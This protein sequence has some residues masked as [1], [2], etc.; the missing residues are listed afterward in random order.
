MSFLQGQDGQQSGQ[1]KWTQGLGFVSVSGSFSGLS[2]P[3]AL[4]RTWVL[5][6]QP[7]PLIKADVS[8]YEHRCHLEYEG[9]SRRITG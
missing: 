7:D 6:P 9:V 8:L 3:V 2:L 1:S 4:M 5:L